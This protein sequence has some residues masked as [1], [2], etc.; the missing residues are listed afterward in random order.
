MIQVFSF[1]TRLKCSLL[2]SLDTNDLV[3]L[4]CKLHLILL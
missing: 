1:A 4:D 3:E 2:K